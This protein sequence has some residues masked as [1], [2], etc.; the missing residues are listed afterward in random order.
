MSPVTIPTN[1]TTI[2]Q[3]RYHRERNMMS[4][5]QPFLK[6][7]N[8]IIRNCYRPLAFLR[9]ILGRAQCLYNFT[10]TSPSSGA[11]GPIAI[12]NTRKFFK[13]SDNCSKQILI[14]TAN[15]FRWECQRNSFEQKSYICC[16]KN[17]YV[18]K[19]FIS[20]NEASQMN[21]LEELFSTKIYGLA[22]LL[23]TRNEIDLLGK[24]GRG[25]ETCFILL[26]NHFMR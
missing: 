24:D 9:K 5:L 2:L 17:S 23:E 14:R 4:A 20:L 10:C 12:I 26:T 19:Y 16:L 15:K 11:R 18:W 1:Y 3:R 22:Y 13:T 8:T 6:K 21:S 25:R 7:N